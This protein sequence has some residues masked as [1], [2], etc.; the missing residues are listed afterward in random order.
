[1]I[2]SALS[3]PLKFFCELFEHDEA[4]LCWTPTQHHSHIRRFVFYGAPHN[5][6][7]LWTNDFE[8]PAFL[9]RI[10]YVYWISSLQITHSDR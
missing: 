8:L 10:D 5:K 6:S 1:M 3:N 7:N 9:H 4:E 2:Q